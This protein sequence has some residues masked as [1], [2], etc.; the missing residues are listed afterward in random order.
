MNPFSI[1]INISISDPARKAEI[2]QAFIAHF[3][4]VGEGETPEHFVARRTEEW[5]LSIYAN[6]TAEL[7]VSNL[8]VSTIEAVRT[9]ET[10]KQQPKPE[11]DKKK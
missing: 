8:H 1:N 5:L 9:A 3:G 4:G 10:I 7:A 6:K 11:E 2:E